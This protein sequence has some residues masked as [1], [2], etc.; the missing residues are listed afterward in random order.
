MPKR[1][2]SDILING[3]KFELNKINS[4]KFYSR[5]KICEEYAIIAKNRKKYDPRLDNLYL[6]NKEVFYC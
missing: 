4:E 1:N 5:M 6:K 3:E 2:L